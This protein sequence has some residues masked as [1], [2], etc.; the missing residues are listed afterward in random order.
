MELSNIIFLFFL[1]F[2]GYLFNFLLLNFKRRN[3]DFLLDN[4]FNKPQ[5]FHDQSTYRVGGLLIYLL[6][7]FTFLYLFFYK[8]IFLIEYISFCTFFFLLG[9]IDDLKINIRPKFRLIIMASL[10]VTLILQNELYIEKTGLEFLNYLL[11]IDIFALFFI[12]LCFLFI[13]NGSNLID[14]FNG[15]LGIHSLIIFII[16]FIINLNNT[17]NDFSYFLFCLCLIILIFL[18]FNF[19]Q[20]KIFLGDSGAYIIGTL[21]AISVVKTSILNSSIHPFF[22]CVLLF[23]LF[24]EVF[25]SFLRKIFFSKQNPLFPDSKHLHMSLYK[26]LLKKNENKLNSNYKVSLYINL[27]YLSLIT[28]AIFLMENGLFCRYYFFFLLLAYIYFYRMLYK[29]L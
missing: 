19:P 7:V 26:I 27:I 21:I 16:L 14:G 8:N 9:L 5:A 2:S 12:C 25:F 18:K 17:S 23:Y 15:L 29:K 20:A 22:F 11:K 10:L 6:L 28:P 1:L 4:Q 24:F 3:F 13:I